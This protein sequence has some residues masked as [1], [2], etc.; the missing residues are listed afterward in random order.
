MSYMFL[1]WVLQ[2][3]PFSPLPFY[4]SFSILNFSKPKP[5]LLFW[6]QV[7]S[8]TN[9]F[10]PVVIVINLLYPKYPGPKTH[11]NISSVRF[12]LLIKKPV[13]VTRSSGI[14]CLYGDTPHNNFKDLWG[15]CCTYRTQKKWANCYGHLNPSPAVF[16]SPVGPL[17]IAQLLFPNF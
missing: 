16:M 1:L 2:A 7:A 15:I 6:L 4:S 14:L 3:A 5:C 11:D 12:T 8:F 17:L 10:F 13:T 9:V